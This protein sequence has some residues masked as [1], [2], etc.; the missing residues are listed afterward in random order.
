M[1]EVLCY[2][3]SMVLIAPTKAAPLVDMPSCG[4]SPAGAEFN[5][6]AH[7]A[8]LGHQVAWSSALGADPF[9]EIILNEAEQRAVQTDL[10]VT[11]P[12]RPTGVYFKNPTEA[13]TEV[14]YY[15]QG[16]AA[17][18]LD[19]RRVAE[20]TELTPGIIHTTGITA[21]LSD[22][23]LDSTRALVSERILPEATVSFDVNFRPA[24]WKGGGADDTLLELAQA[25]DIVF[26]GRDEAETVWGVSTAAEIRQLISE[27]T[28][29]I[30]KD[31]D[32]L[33]TEYVGYSAIT[34]RPPRVRVF[35]PVG[36]GDAFAAGWLSA[37]MQK[38]DVDQRLR[39]GHFLASQALQHPGDLFPV[40]SLET[41]SQL[42]PYPPHEWPHH[43]IHSAR[44]ETQHVPG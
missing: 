12:Q 4:L 29:L 34:C 38:F 23:S 9:A 18:A 28:H 8:G 37:Y 19:V 14:F 20:D 24:L 21:A 31:D 33:A 43:L 36:A 10:V 22:A 3:E 5:V 16:S 6:A 44:K 32:V 39:L 13:G 25:S 1:P 15:R 17:S 27:P 7:L 35:E 41:I 26:V 30:I 40:P 11:D 42:L 2:G